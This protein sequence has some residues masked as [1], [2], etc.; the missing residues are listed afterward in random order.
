LNPETVQISVQG[1][2]YTSTERARNIALLRAADLTIEAG[3]QR[4]II[5]GGQ[6]GQEYAGTTGVVVNRV[7]NTLIATG[8]EAIHKPSG[9]M[10][11]RFVEQKDPAFQ[12]AY[13]A[14]LIRSQLL[15]ALAPKS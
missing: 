1:N 2:G 12:S 8:G 10:T 9:N 6:V 11:V 14:N 7:G 3:F 5:L 13:Y 15:P 4:F